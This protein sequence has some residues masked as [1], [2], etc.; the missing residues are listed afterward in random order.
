MKNARLIASPDAPY[1]FASDLAVDDML[2]GTPPYPDLVVEESDV[3]S[4]RAIRFQRM[5][6]STPDG[7]RYAVIRL[8]GLLRVEA[9]A[10]CGTD[11]GDDDDRCPDEACGWVPEVE[12]S[13]RTCLPEGTAPDPR[14]CD[15]CGHTIPDGSGHV[16]QDEHGVDRAYCR[17]CWV[18]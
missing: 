11:M 15:A 3:A 13:E 8:I 10:V 4:I 9:C 14:K 12:I 7:E 18:E 17:A 2:V 6:L 16:E 5:I 1:A